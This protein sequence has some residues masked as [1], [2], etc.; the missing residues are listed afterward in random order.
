[1]FGSVRV[2]GKNPMSVWWKDEIKAAVWR[3][4]AAWNVLAT[5]DE[6]EK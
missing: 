6:G 2:E 1:M 3:K 4:E 5:G